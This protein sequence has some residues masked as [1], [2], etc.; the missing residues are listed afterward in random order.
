MK[1]VDIFYWK[2]ALLLLIFFFILIILPTLDDAFGQKSF[3]INQQTFNIYGYNES[4]VLTQNGV[5]ERVEEFKPNY[6]G[7]ILTLVSIFSIVAL[8]LFAKKQKEGYFLALLLGGFLIFVSL[9]LILDPILYRS[10]KGPPIG[11]AFFFVLHTNLLI[12]SCFFVYCVWKSKS[13][14]KIK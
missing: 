8:V 7:V 11:S 9:L 14:F 3:S 13:I 2:A 10:S 6:Y 5:S 4:F 12:L 1:I